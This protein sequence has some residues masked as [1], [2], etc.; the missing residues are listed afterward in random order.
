LGGAVSVAAVAS[1]GSR[2]MKRARSVAVVEP[3]HALRAPEDT[4]SDLASDLAATTTLT[5]PTHT[6]AT[7]TPTPGTPATTATAATAATR[8]V[9]AAGTATTPRGG[10][11][12]RATRGGIRASV[13]TLAGVWG[14][15]VE[16]AAELLENVEQR[17]SV[18]ADTQNADRDTATCSTAP[19][20][21]LTPSPS[22]TFEGSQEPPPM[23]GDLE[24]EPD[25]L[26]PML[27]AKTPARHDLLLP[28]RGRAWHKEDAANNTAN[29]TTVAAVGKSYGTVEAGSNRQLASNHSCDIYSCDIY[30]SGHSFEHNH[31]ILRASSA[32]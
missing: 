21:P 12:A 18:V 14:I 27:F 24:R 3:P 30:H 5:P 26:T 1:T 17:Q 31:R 23:N 10:G 32:A 13:L 28:T 25:E 6:A 20:L 19:P 15:S 4:A 8:D 9:H 2:A 29:N 22:P 16:D 7:P 11:R